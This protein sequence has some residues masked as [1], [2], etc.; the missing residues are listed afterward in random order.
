MML[1]SLL[2]IVLMLTRPH[3]LFYAEEEGAGREE[4]GVEGEIEVRSQRSEVRGQKPEPE[5][6]CEGCTGKD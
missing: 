5:F 2:L 1:Y 4:D 3:G 6:S